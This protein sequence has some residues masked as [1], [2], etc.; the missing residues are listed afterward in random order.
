MSVWSIY[1]NLATIFANAASISTFFCLC[2]IHILSRR[3]KTYAVTFAFWVTQSCFLLGHAFCLW[4]GHWCVHIYS[5][6]FFTFLIK[7]YFCSLYIARVA[8]TV[9]F[10]QYLFDAE[11][12]SITVKA[13]KYCK[14]AGEALST[15][16]HRLVSPNL[17]KPWFKFQKYEWRKKSPFASVWNSRVLYRSDSQT[18]QTAY[19][20]N[21]IS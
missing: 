19:I 8:A 17:F 3:L 12:P 20:S 2:H 10:T 15:A 16:E 4:P 18:P 11:K 9:T 13:T 14:V 7:M 5:H 1:W 21:V 6:R